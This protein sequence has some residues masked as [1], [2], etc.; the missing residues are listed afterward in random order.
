MCGLRET[1]VSSFCLLHIFTAA[2]SLSILRVASFSSVPLSSWVSFFIFFCLL[3]PLPPF[4]FHS[5]IHSIII[6][7]CCF[8][9][10]QTFTAGGLALLSREALCSLARFGLCLH[11]PLIYAFPPPL[12]WTAWLFPLP[13]S[14]PHRPALLTHCDLG[15]AGQGQP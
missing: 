4:P 3:L 10:M 7:G 9:R 1:V 12:N 6:Y 14:W 15:I 11:C 5:R 8:S 2:L 13:Q